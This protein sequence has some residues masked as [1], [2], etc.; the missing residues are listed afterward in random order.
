MTGWF[1]MWIRY[2]SGTISLP[3]HQ[4]EFFKIYCFSRCWVGIETVSNE[5]KDLKTNFNNFHAFEQFSLKFLK[6]SSNYFNDGASLYIMNV[7][8]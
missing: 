8:E 6:S 7:A 2:V 5:K 3:M 1:G 4:F